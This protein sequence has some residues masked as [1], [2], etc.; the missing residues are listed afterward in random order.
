MQI[1]FNMIGYLSVQVFERLDCE[2]VLAKLDTH[3]IVT[4]CVHLS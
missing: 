1:L 2:S 3:E 4:Y